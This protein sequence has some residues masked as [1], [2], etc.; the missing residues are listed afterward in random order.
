MRAICM[1]C[2]H[3][4]EPGNKCE[5]FPDGIPDG[6][7]DGG[8]DHR[9][10]WLNAGEMLFQLTADNPDAEVWLDMYEQQLGE[11]RPGAT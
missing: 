6:I 9:K 2:A 4:Q 10:P 11:G 8:F 5:A 3:R 1:A 7:I